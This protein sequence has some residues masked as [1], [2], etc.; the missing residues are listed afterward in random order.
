MKKHLSLL[1]FISCA[2]IIFAAVPHGYYSSADGRRGESL[3][4]QLQAIISSGYT[5]ISYGALETYYPCIDF[6]ENGHLMDIYSVCT[7]T[8]AEANVAQ[9]T[10]C[11]GWNKEHCVPQSWFGASSPMKSDLFQVLPTDARVNNLRSNYPYG[12]TSSRNDAISTNAKALGHLG[13]CSFAGY[14]GKVY[15]PDDEYKGD[16][17]RIYFYMVTRYHDRNLTSGTGSSVFT[18]SP[19]NLTSFALSLFLKWHRDD[20]VSEKELKRNDAVY[21]VQHNRNPFVDYPELV[22]IIWGAR[23]GE[24]VNFS[25][26]TSA[27]DG[28]QPVLP[29]E[30]I[31][32]I[33]VTWSNNGVTLATWLLPSADTYTELPKASA[34]CSLSSTQFVGWT[35]LPIQGVA[36]EVPQDLFSDISELPD[37][38]DDIT[39][40][41]VFAEVTEDGTGEAVTDVGMTRDSYVGWTMTNTISETKFFR[42]VSGASISSPV[43]NL[44]A[45]ES[46]TVNMRTYG[47]TSYNN[48]TISANGDVIAT[49]TATNG[50]ILTDYTWQR[51]GEIFTGSVPFV[52]TC[53]NATSAN[54]TAVATIT[55]TMAGVRYVYSDFITHCSQT[56]DAE[57]VINPDSYDSNSRGTIVRKILRNGQLLIIYGEREYTVLGVENCR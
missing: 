6:D 3:L 19:T 7:F 15:E 23:S 21:A 40:N 29:P 46:I 24:S 26:L 16:I 38:D 14:T 5:T 33:H 18:S 54:S 27:Y 48:L 42:L 31:D 13:S 35:A 52:F 39:F 51:N 2:S 44:E 28:E 53:N 55:I 11:Q 12:E 50:K 22:E 47:G 1:L 41:A 30:P 10:F 43:I 36:D 17:A 57:I 8:M 56:T 4:S 45:L 32:T 37:I 9:S 25:T 49:L 34:S 20:P